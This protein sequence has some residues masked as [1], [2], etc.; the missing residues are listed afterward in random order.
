M[1]LRRDKVTRRKGDT[2]TDRADIC[3]PG[4]ALLRADTAGGWKA[5]GFQR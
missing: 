1:L 3:F 4:Q 5:N 2:K